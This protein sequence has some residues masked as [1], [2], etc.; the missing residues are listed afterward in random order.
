MHAFLAMVGIA[1]A[2]VPPVGPRST[3]I[4]TN[5]GRW[6]SPYPVTPRRRRE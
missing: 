6:R 1:L 4:P 3:S 2:V 5:W